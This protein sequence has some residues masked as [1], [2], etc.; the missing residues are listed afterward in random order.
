MTEFA[1]EQE[2][3]ASAGIEMQNRTIENVILPVFTAQRSSLL[4]F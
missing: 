1:W 3:P 2:I 4:A